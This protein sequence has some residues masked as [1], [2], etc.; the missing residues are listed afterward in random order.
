MAKLRGDAGC[1]LPF[2]IFVFL[3]PVLM[4]DVFVSIAMTKAQM[5]FIGLSLHAE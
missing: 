1:G 3:S 2:E 4:A 5:V